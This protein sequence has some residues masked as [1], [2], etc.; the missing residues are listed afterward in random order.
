MRPRRIE[1]WKV[2]AIVG[3]TLVALLAGIATTLAPRPW[4]T[5]GKIGVLAIDVAVWFVVVGCSLF[6]E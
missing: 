3:M 6:A 1:A 2:F 4:T 5:A